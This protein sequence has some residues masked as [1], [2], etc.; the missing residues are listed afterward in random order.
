MAGYEDVS[1]DFIGE[2]MEELLLCEPD[3]ERRVKIR[4]VLDRERYHVVTPGDEK[5]AVGHLLFQECAVVLAGE[6]FGGR[7]PGE[8]PLV[9]H[10]RR[11][12]SEARRNLFV[13]LLSETQGTAD[14][15]AAFRQ[16]VNL[17]VNYED[18]ERLPA[19]LRKSRQDAGEGYGPFR[20]SLRRAGRM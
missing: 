6:R 5:E 4:E 12:S 15:M 18:L 16:S 10:L 7:A 11:L 20:E 1:L 19:I 9:D 14:V 8:G 2:G 13:A 17:V 3:E